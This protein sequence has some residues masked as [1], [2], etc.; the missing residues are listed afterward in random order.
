MMFSIPIIIPFYQHQESESEHKERLE[1]DRQTAQF[2]A[3]KYQLRWEKHQWDNMDYSKTYFIVW[4]D[5]VRECYCKKGQLQPKDVC[6]FVDEGKL[7]L[8]TTRLLCQTKEEAEE[9]LHKL[10]EPSDELV[11]EPWRGTYRVFNK[12]TGEVVKIL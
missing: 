5:T 4:N 3:S 11:M 8:I 12:T 7:S 6:C 9:K 2:E 1:R 10:K